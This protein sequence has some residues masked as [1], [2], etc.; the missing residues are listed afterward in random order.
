MR[1]R[2]IPAALGLAAAL[3]PADGLRADLYRCPGA[4]GG[5]VFTDNPGACPGAREHQPSAVIQKVPSAPPARAARRPATAGRAA[6]Q[7]QAEADRARA[8]RQ[9]KTQKEQELRALTSRRD[10]LLEYVSWCNRGGELIRRDP[11]GL[12]RKV[13]CGQVRGELGSLETQMATVQAYLDEGLE[14][15]CR[16]AGC[17]PGWIR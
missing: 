4:D 10:D 14:E 15:E 1:A 7:Q 6:M 16:R 12:N 11:S 8:W 3:Y 5:T 17:L 13:S 9:K 2:W